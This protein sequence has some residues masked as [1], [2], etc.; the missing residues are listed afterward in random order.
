MASRTGL[1][2]AHLRL[3]YLPTVFH[4]YADLGLLYPLG[5]LVCSQEPVQFL[6]QA[7]TVLL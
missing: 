5:T 7:D 4:D 1:D 6:P 3:A 2:I